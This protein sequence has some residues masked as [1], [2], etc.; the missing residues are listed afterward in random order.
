MTSLSSTILKI[1]RMVGLGTDEL[2]TRLTLS[3]PRRSKTLER[4]LE[5]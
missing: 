1:P 2:L 3:Q 5:H 4:S